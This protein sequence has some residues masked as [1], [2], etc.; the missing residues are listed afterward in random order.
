M[1]LYVWSYHIK[2]CE[3]TLTLLDSTLPVPQGAHFPTYLSISLK[4]RGKQINCQGAQSPLDINRGPRNPSARTPPPTAPQGTYRVQTDSDEPTGAVTSVKQR[5]NHSSIT[6]EH[7]WLGVRLHP[8]DH[9]PCYMA[10][11]ITGIY[12]PYYRMGRKQNCTP[13]ELNPLCPNHNQVVLAQ[14]DVEYYYMYYNKLIIS[15]LTKPF[16]VFVWSIEAGSL[17]GIINSYYWEEPLQ[18]T[19]CANTMTP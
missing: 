9:T 18:E 8:H 16:K 10:K 4:A 12:M 14:S 15:W 7:T 5:T 13:P 19:S 2:S 3:I 1:R 11:G 17:S 6:H